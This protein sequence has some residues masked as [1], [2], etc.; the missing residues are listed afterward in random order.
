MC[1]S[2][3]NQVGQFVGCFP[4]LRDD[5]GGR[6]RFSLNQGCRNKTLAVSGFMWKP[7]PE[8][9]G[10]PNCAKLSQKQFNSVVD[11]ILSLLPYLKINLAFIPH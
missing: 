5:K 1:A 8:A 2:V 10:S 7:K 3:S 6:G 4:A 9:G 11:T